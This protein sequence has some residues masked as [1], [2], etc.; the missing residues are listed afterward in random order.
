LTNVQGYNIVIFIDF[1]HS[2]NSDNTNFYCWTDLMFVL[3]KF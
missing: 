1:T 3:R 2:H